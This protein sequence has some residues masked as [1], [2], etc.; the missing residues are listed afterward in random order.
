MTGR[1]HKLG[2]QTSPETRALMR[3]SSNTEGRH[4]LTNT[5]RQTISA[6]YP[7]AEIIRAVDSKK[8][9]YMI[10]GMRVNVR[11]ATLNRSH[12]WHFTILKNRV[13]DRFF[14]L[15]FDTRASHTLLHAFCIPGTEINHLTGV[16]I[17]EKT[18]TKCE[19]W[20]IGIPDQKV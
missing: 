7:R 2:Y 13:P 19:E 4:D 5:V 8:P 18:L 3:A 1:Q 9:D 6:M 10:D 15:L 14:F 17:S 11:G 20:V 16:S 12:R